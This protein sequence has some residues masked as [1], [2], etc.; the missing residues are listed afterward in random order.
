MVCVP[1]TLEQ[2]TAKVVKLS[3]AL[4]DR[5]TAV[6]K[7]EDYFEGRHKLKFASDEWRK[8]HEQRYRNFSDNWCE[9][10]GRAAPER[11]EIFG[12]R[13]GDDADVQSRDE[14]A[15]WRDWEINEGPAQSAQ[16][17]LSSAVTSTS[18]A[19]V[20][21]NDDDEPVL[22]WEHASQ[23]I[24]EYADDGR[25]PLASLK[26]WS[27]G[28][29]EFATLY[30]DDEVFKFQRRT[31]VSGLV[32]P[33]NLGGWE[34]R[35]IDRPH[36]PN[37]LGIQPMV[38]FPNRPLLKKGAISDIE[39][40]MAMQDAINLMWAYLFSSADFAS[41]PAR[42]VMGQEP[43]KIPVLD[44]QGQ[45]VGERPVDP[46][47]LKN[48]RMLWLTGQNTKVGQWDAA[49]LDVFTDALNVMV[50]HT[51]SQT[52]TPIH[53]IMGELGNVNGETLTATE[54]PLAGKVREGH[55]HLT[56]P[57]R[58]I[59]RRMAL[60]RGQSA[61]A[62]ACRTAQVQWKNPETASD[63]Q[64]SDAALKDTQVGWPFAAVLERRY[65]LSQPEIERVMSMADS[66]PIVAAARSLTAGGS[67][68]AGSGG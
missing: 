17:F 11:T 57:A 66:D 51:A 60:V 3:D 47:V 37:P 1:L 33:A 68:A 38:E 65:G 58:G 6:D 9:V 20:W 12:L 19:L 16:G 41:M 50:K 27:D 35:Q 8:A 28:D 26:Q 4:R 40:T 2:A 44:E 24:I 7:R 31:G 36:I 5:R 13:L 18:Y 10:V 61:V 53:Y 43:P 25:T 64:V 62:E 59:F 42:V 29:L 63:S 39:G 34:L 54:L 32:L 67:G 15:L 21:G 56:G 45:K 46:E 30:L 23:A 55:K 49:K 14:K 48:G 22:T 52:R